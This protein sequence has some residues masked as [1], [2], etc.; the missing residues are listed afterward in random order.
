MPRITTEAHRPVLV[1]CPQS[2]LDVWARAAVQFAPG[3]R[4]KV[5]RNREDLDVKD[6]QENIDMLVLNYAQLRVCGDLLNE[7]KWLPDSKAAKCARELDS[8]NRLVLTGTPIENRLLDMWSLMAFAMPGV[9]GS[10]AYFQKR[11]DKDR[12]SVV[13]GKCGEL[14][15]AQAGQLEAVVHGGTDSSRS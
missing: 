14:T 7:I 6:T 8:A 1:V 5:L 9:L 11:F 2:V 4:V 13:E 15:G 10:R 12:K 3:V